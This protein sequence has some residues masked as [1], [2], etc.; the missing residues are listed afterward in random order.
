[1]KGVPAM[2]K[3]RMVDK[4]NFRAFVYGAKGERKLV[5]SWDEF[6]AKMQSG[7][8]FASK[9][10]AEAVKSPSEKPKP[11]SKPRP[12]RKAKVEKVEDEPIDELPDD[13]SVIEVKD[14][15][16]SNEKK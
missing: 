8:W 4:N 15:I 11:V 1:M 6:E 9:D 5:E 2:Y 14:D 12:A 13:G 7:L 10:D 16:L 3:G